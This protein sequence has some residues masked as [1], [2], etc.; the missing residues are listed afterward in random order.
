M[1]DENFRLIK[2]SYSSVTL[3][4]HND[5]VHDKTHY[6]TKEELTEILNQQMLEQ[7]SMFMEMINSQ[8]LLFQQ[9]MDKYN[10]HIMKN[11]SCIT[12]ELKNITEETLK[13]NENVIKRPPKSKKTKYEVPN[14]GTDKQFELSSS[15]VTISPMFS[16]EQSTSPCSS[17][18]VSSVEHQMQI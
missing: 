15:T 6:V 4:S 7:K 2:K 5:H 1:L 12:L 16:V 13:Q 3:T 18:T 14:I 11:I 8:A 9:T 17:K 10:E